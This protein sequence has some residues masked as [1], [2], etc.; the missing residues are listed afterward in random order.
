MRQGQFV[1][2]E[3]APVARRTYRLRLAGDHGFSAP[4][5]FAAVAIDGFYLRR[6]LSV[7]DFDDSGFSTIYKCVGAG[8]Q[9]L[10]GYDPGRTVDAL[11]GLGHGFSAGQTERPLLIG[12]GVGVPPLYGLARALRRTGRPV[13][14]GLGFNRDDEVFLADDFAA[15]GCQVGVTTVEPGRYDTGLVTSLLP[16]F[17]DCDRYFACGPEPMLR[18]LTAALAIPGQVSLE[19]RMAC[20]FGACRGCSLTTAGGQKRLCFEGPVLDAQ[21][22]IWPT[23]A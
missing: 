17:A 12:G 9:A 19:T 7:C 1:V 22:V 20:G 18:A 15:L 8:T 14:V 4:G 13:A 23:R 3:N 2:Q 5:Q 10:A 11:T 21:E 16:R 6:P